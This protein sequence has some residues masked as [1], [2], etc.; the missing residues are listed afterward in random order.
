MRVLCRS[1][2]ETPERASRPMSASAG[3]FVPGSGAGVLM[4][5]SL[6][7][8]LER[9]ATIHAEV[10]GGAVNPFFDVFTSFLEKRASA[11]VIMMW[12]QTVVMAVP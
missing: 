2:N 4:L 6:T 10:A 7:S 12:K 9:G 8:A 1:M 5:E 11:N 3:G